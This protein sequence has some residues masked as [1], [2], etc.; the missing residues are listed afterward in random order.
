V[1]LAVEN[2][3]RPAEK[4]QRP[5][6]RRRRRTSLLAHG[7]PLVWLTGGALAL[8]LAMISGLLGLV[9][10]Q[11]GRTFWSRPI[12]RVETL[13]GDVHLGQVTKRSQTPGRDDG[14][15]L[16]ER[17]RLLRTENFELTQTHYLWVSDSQV[18]TETR[19]EWAILA[20]RYDG[21]P[22]YGIPTGLF[23]DGERTAS[24]PAEVWN[25]FG[26][27]HPEVLARL[28][29]RERLETEPIGE[30]N[31]RLEEA[32]LQL[33]RAELD[34]GQGSPEW[35]TAERNHD[36]VVEQ[37]DVDTS[38]VRTDISALNEVNDKY[39]LEL[40]TGDGVPQRIPLAGIVRLVP[41]N[42][43]DFAGKLALYADRWGEFLTAEPRDS[44]T[45]GGVFPPI[46]GTV[47]MTLIMSFM[48]VPF[49]VLAALY[50]R[51]YAK[52]GNM[53]S[54]VRIAV[55]NLAGVPSIVFGVFGLG[56]FCYLIGGSI[57]SV[58]FSESLP[59]PT[60]GKGGL[61]WASLTLALLT[62]PVVIVATE[63]ALA[64]VP[65]SM[66]EGSYACG[67]T[68]WQTVRRIVLPRAAPGIMT[69]MILAIARG[70][71]EVAPLML[72]GVVAVAPELPS[73]LHPERRFMH[74][75]FHVYE[76]GF[77][78]P[79]AEAARPLVFTT[80]LLLIAIVVGLNLAAIWIRARLRRKF[81]TG[82]H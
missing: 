13:D 63:E 44:N 34:H 36:L 70:A 41:A 7:E 52:Q 29:E 58:F 23:V 30:I 22:F 80:T 62:L 51:E 3:A 72:V 39:Q 14:S 59:N 11:G 67:A 43:L 37:C 54:A 76:V 73:L 17:R 48:V 24:E 31:A 12:V 9:V 74:L 47:L 57:D 28:R 65:N 1:S 27:Y 16:P 10:Y 64:A 60:F 4:G 71:G 32:R 46:F 19:P 18:A 26:E 66:R 78:S 68:K 45:A 49:G 77:Q 61:L 25:L 82:I 55:G 75:G 8:C 5:I 6:R 40:T 2:P 50:L 38:R 56:F 35:L 42:Q 33:R 81:S 53:V 69:G 79:N 15:V 21:G 20:E